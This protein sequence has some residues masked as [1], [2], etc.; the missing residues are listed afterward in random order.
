M[1]FLTVGYTQMEIEMM[2]C[3]EIIKLIFNGP[4]MKKISIKMLSPIYIILKKSYYYN[5]YEKYRQRYAIDPTFRFNG[6]SINFY[7]DG[8]ILCGRNSYIGEHSSVQAS[9]G[10]KVA[11]GNNVSIS[12]F[13]MIYTKNNEPDQ[14]FSSVP[15]KIKKGDVIIEDFCWIGAKVFIKEGIT[16]GTN[17]VIGAGSVVVHDIPSNCVAAGVPAK[18]IYFKSCAELGWHGVRPS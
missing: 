2:K 14:D 5:L 12:H 1:V 7:G 3:E 17:S 15:R 13:V 18:P 10:C 8:E 9:R 4:I 6:Y 16:I 11:I